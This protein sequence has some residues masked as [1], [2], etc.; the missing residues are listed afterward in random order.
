MAY[1]GLL[2][3]AFGQAW[4]LIEVRAIKGLTNTSVSLILSWLMFGRSLLLRML[5]PDVSMD[6]SNSCKM[7]MAVRHML[8]TCATVGTGPVASAVCCL[9]AQASDSYVQLSY[10]AA[11][12]T[13]LRWIFRTSSYSKDEAA[14]VYCSKTGNGS[15]VAGCALL[16]TCHEATRQRQE[17][18]ESSRAF[19]A[20]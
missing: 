9:I 2:C 18:L 15:Q 14:T 5:Y 1:M 8:K 3:L 19:C 10:A 4:D 6:V 17:P 11:V 16:S 7:T 12:L 20:S 13:L